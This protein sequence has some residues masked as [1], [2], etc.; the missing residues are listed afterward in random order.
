M[1][2]PAS[3]WFISLRFPAWWVQR[4]SSNR[5]LS[6]KR[7]AYLGSVGRWFWA[8]K[9]DQFW[10]FCVEKTG[11]KPPI[12]GK[13]NIFGGKTSDKPIDLGVSHFQRKLEV[14]NMT[15]NHVPDIL[16]RENRTYHLSEKHH[17][18]LL[19]D[20]QFIPIPSHQMAENQQAHGSCRVGR[21]QSQPTCYKQTSWINMDISIGYFLPQFVVKTIFPNQRR[22]L[23]FTTQ[24]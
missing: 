4:C 14:G 19:E 20:V 21:G 13:F 7:R 11:E 5:G 17:W 3:I 6:S 24:I 23:S 12:D 8:S 2:H 22:G 16:T 18:L 10:Q 9:R 15:C 1:H